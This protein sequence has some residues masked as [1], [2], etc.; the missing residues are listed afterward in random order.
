[1][2]PEVQDITVKDIVS[3]DS[4]K[5][6]EDAIIKMAS[7]NLR[8]IVVTDNKNYQ[9][10]T[11]TKLIDLKLEKVNP[12]TK[13]KDLDLKNVKRLHKHLNILSILNQINSS[14][15]YMVVIDEDDSLIGIISYTDIINHIDPQVLMKKQT[16]GKLLLNYKAIYIQKNSSTLHAIKLMKKSGTDS[17]IIKDDRKVV[18]IFTTK[19]FINLIHLDCDLTQDISNFMTSP[20]VTLHEKATISDALDFIKEQKFKRIVV[21]D[22]NNEV[23]GII[24]QKELL[25]VV[26]N[27]WIDLVKEEGN[28]ISKTNEELLQSKAE[29]EEIASYDYLTKVYNRHKFESFLDYEINRLSRYEEP[30]FSLLLIDLDYFKSINDKHGHLK[31]DQVLIE[32]ANILRV[33]SRQSDIIAR[34]GGEEFIMLLPHTNIEES[35]YVAEKLRSTIE[36]HDF[37]DDLNVTCSIGLAQFHK[38]DSKVELFKRADKALYRAKDLGRNQVIIESIECLN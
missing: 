24:T 19:D 5:T 4:N 20:I 18:G 13:L 9:I 35:I 1:V 29:L 26:Y 30:T 34:W 37:K 36:N 11:T 3:I 23:S 8:T 21:V 7:S 28:R 17:I 16:I 10:L 31:G 14:D 6:L 15:E 32:V 27:K 22:D 38:S 12:N 33:C 25:R 2:L